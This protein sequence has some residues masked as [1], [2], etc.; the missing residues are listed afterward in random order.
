MLS[1]GA[2][3]LAWLRLSGGSAAAL[4]VAMQFMLAS[5]APNILALQF[6]FT[7]ASFQSV[8]DAWQAQGV[9]AYRAHFP[10]DFAFLLSYGVFGHL[11]ATRV[12]ERS[13]LD[14]ASSARARWLAPAAALCD[15]AENLAHLHLLSSALAPQAL[16]VALSATLA[17]AKWLLLVGFAATMIHARLRRA[18]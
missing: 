13:G 18:A 3:Q 5:L 16:L 2:R 9:A 12:A 1:S 10:F 17:L 4:F 6:A 14:A 11:W 7:P 15:A 8:I